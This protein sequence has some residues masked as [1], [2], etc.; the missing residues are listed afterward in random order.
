MCYVALKMRTAITILIISLALDTFCQENKTTIND[1]VSIHENLEEMPVFPGGSSAFSNW[2]VDF[3]QIIN[4]DSLCNPVT[5]YISFYVDSTGHVK[6]PDFFFRNSD[7]PECKA[8]E[9]YLNKLKSTLIAK[10]P[11][12]KP[13]RK[14][15]KNVGRSFTIPMKYN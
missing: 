14:N 13:A 2:L 8:E 9:N 12:W 3:S 1:S 6:N 7:N 15:N 5:L 4:P 10:M 11:I